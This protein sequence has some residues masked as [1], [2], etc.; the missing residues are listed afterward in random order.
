MH[1][2]RAG[3]L[4]NTGRKS[5]AFGMVVMLALSPGWGVANE[6]EAVWPG[7]P[8]FSPADALKVS[9]D[10]PESWDTSAPVIITWNVV[11]DHAFL[12]SGA[13][14]EILDNSGKVVQ[15]QEWHG[16][17]V[18]G[19]NAFPISWDASTAAPGTYV[20]RLTLDYAEDL[21]LFRAVIP[22]ERVSAAALRETAREAAAQVAA[23][24]QQVENETESA[25]RTAERIRLRT[26]DLAQVRFNE[27]VELGQWRRAHELTRYMRETLRT[28]AARLS[29][30]VGQAAEDLQSSAPDEEGWVGLALDTSSP[31][32]AMRTLELARDL[33]M[34]HGLLAVDALP[35]AANEPFNPDR[36]ASWLTPILDRADVLGIYLVL[37]FDQNQLAAWLGGQLPEAIAEGYAN[38]A[39]DGFSEALKSRMRAVAAVARP[40]QARIAAVSVATCPEMKFDGESIRNRFVDEVKKRYEDD[41]QSLNQ[42]WRSHLASFDEITIWGEYPEH[43]YHH[44]RAFKYDWQ[45][46]HQGLIAERLKDIAAAARESFPGIPV[47]VTQNDEVLEAEPITR[48]CRTDLDDIFDWTAYVSSLKADNAPY[49]LDYP[50]M[51]AIP[52]AIRATAPEKPLVNLGLEVDFQNLPLEKRADMARVLILDT[53]LNDVT[54]VVIPVAAQSPEVLEG[55]ALAALDIRC[56]P[57][58]PVA[59][60]EA[61]LEVGVLFSESSKIFDDG[62]P[63][64]RSARFAFEGT[65]FIGAKVGFINEHR[66]AEDGLPPLL[67]LVLPETPALLNVTFD[68]LA[69]YLDAGGAVARP[70][71]PIP[72]DE[73]G[74][75][76]AD[77]LLNTGNTVYVRGLNLPTEYL[78][79]MDALQT[80]GALPRFP[81]PINGYGYPLEGVKSRFVRVDNRGWLFVLNMRPEPVLCNLDGG[82]QSGM[83]VLTGTQVDF[84]RVLE[85]LRPLLIRLN[86]AGVTIEN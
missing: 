4:S 29:F 18:A 86:D 34:R 65:T 83:D 85:P 26:M 35:D 22:L 1:A 25:T 33:G 80:R 10:L 40:Y 32:A 36:V 78:H 51:E 30:S 11:A 2:I 61:P 31:D 53:L 16:H 60:R 42:A 68:A 67:A 23:I 56:C 62:E 72:Y 28:L 70:G 48:P 21:P 6:Y 71:T 14:L 82:Q 38:L 73:R 84:P 77:V 75:S 74:H 52:A 43:D 59:F 46:F 63:H 76:R 58:V 39:V 49:A 3:F 13:L 45:R 54:G 7:T 64:L 44:K 17:I 8:M 66:V 50:R 24:R 37:Q 69:S 5:L 19:Q 15:S 79:A 41:R 27:A 57:R 55:A 81:R 9:A 20:A 12:N 47:T